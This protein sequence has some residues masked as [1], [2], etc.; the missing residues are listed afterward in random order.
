MRHSGIVRIKFCGIARPE[1]AKTAAR[2]GASYVGV[3]FADSPRRV[4]EE[5]AR[6]VFEAAGE[7]LGRV[8][9]FGDESIENIAATASRIGADIVQ[10]HSASGASAVDELRR[11]FRGRIWAVISI[12]P[13]SLMLP[14]ETDRLAA[15]A[16]AL[17]LDA[18]VGGR[19]GGTGRTLNWDALAESVAALSEQTE[20][21]LAGGLTPENVATAIRAMRPEVVD[22]SSG[23]ER[24]PGVKDPLRM[25]AFAEGVRSASIVGEKPALPTSLGSE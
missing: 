6:A 14:A 16:D 23:V 8:A 1:D 13:H 10:L 24:S 20:L 18:R 17:L 25:E 21:I 9:V 12:D 3:I 15:A 11:R 5:T 22:V 19:S 4:D 7:N 2:L